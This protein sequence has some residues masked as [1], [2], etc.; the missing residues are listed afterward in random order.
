MYTDVT[1]ALWESVESLP[2]FEADTENIP[3]IGSLTSLIPLQAPSLPLKEG[4][5]SL[6][7]TGLKLCIHSYWC[8][9]LILCIH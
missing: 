3:C 1:G 4:T 6:S 5:C 8:L 7:H 9:N 2:L